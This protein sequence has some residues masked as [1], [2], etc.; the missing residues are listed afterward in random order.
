M[1]LLERALDQAG[2]RLEHVRLLVCTHAHADHYG[3]AGPIVEATGCELWM[4]PDHAAPDEGGGG[5]RR[6]RFERRL[7]VARQSGDPVG[8]L[9]G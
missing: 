4:H 6:A 8:A 7:E 3:L 1:H 9:G 5:P 2:L